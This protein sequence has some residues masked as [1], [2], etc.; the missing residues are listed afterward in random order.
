MKLNNSTGSFKDEKPP[1]PV[2]RK[3]LC[4]ARHSQETH[5]R[6]LPKATRSRLPRRLRDD[7]CSMVLYQCSSS[8]SIL[9]HW[10][11]PPVTN[12]TST[13]SGIRQFR[14]VQSARIRQQPH[15]GFSC[16]P[17]MTR[18]DYFYN[19]DIDDRIRHLMASVRLQDQH[20]EFSAGVFA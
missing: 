9:Q 4:S 20:F 10:W 7:S 8:Q 15:D 2:V 11:T 6:R 18:I 14:A 5:R 12:G 16:L 3:P 13:V 1:L 17:I 19:L